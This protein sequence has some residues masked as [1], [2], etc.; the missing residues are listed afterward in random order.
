[1]RGLI[2]FAAFCFVVAVLL[3]PLGVA[4]AFAVGLAGALATH[5]AGKGVPRRTAGA[6]R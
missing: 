6:R 5:L 2:G 1:M 3:V 4:A